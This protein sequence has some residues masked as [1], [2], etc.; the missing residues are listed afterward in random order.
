MSEVNN[1]FDF[2]KYDIG[3]TGATANDGKLTGE[4][5]EKARADGWNVWDRYREGS[6]CHKMRTDGEEINFGDKKIKLGNKFGNV[7]LTDLWNAVTKMHDK[8]K[9]YWSLFK[10]VANERGLYTLAERASKLAGVNCEDAELLYKDM[11]DDRYSQSPEQQK[12]LEE[13]KQEADRRYN[14]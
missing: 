7:K 5:V 12:L 14:S 6:E 2:K 9:E 3:G 4:E 1:N 10:Q 13:I 11:Y 8:N